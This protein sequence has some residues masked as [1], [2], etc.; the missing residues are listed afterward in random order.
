[1]RGKTRKDCRIPGA[2]ARPRRCPLRQRQARGSA[3][4]GRPPPRHRPHPAGAQARPP[5][6]GGHPRRDDR[7][8]RWHRAALGQPRLRAPRRTWS[9]RHRGQGRL[10]PGQRVQARPPGTGAQGADRGAR[11]P[12]RD[13]PPSP[14]LLRL[15]PPGERAHRPHPVSRNPP[16]SR[17]RVRA[18]R[19]SPETARLR[20][21]RRWCGLVDR[22][23]GH[24]AAPPGPQ[25]HRREPLQQRHQEMR[26]Q[27]PRRDPLD[28][29]APAHEP[30]PVGGR[31]RR[32]R[33]R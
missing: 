16:R 29:D 10:P 33:R 11:R 15:D 6:Q 9:P 22:R 8:R 13:A 18:L 20:P 14:R 23:R 5:R 31:A 7:P 19:K 26:P 28:R 17:W 3:A 27:R 25:G 32:G 24:R 2:L 1:M 12:R 21:G 30:G 4:P